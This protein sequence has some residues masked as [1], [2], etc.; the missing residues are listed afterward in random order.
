MGD[1]SFD[2][3]NFS[4][5]HEFSDQQDSLI[6]EAWFGEATPSGLERLRLMKITSD[7]PEAMWALI[8]IGI[9]QLDFDF[10]GYGNK[11]CERLT[12]SLKD[13]R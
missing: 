10:V 7:C 6:L 8:Q 2:L 13:P 4:A 12:Q 5:H 9:S 3:A 1:P 11:H